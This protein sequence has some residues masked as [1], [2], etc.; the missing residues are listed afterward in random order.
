MQRKWIHLCFWC[1][2]TSNDNRLLFKE[3]YSTVLTVNL[4]TVSLLLHERQSCCGTRL[5]FRLVSA[6][7]V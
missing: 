5:H 3:A 2:V 1:G 7:A 6:C 4:P